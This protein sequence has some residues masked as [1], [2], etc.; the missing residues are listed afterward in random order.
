MTTY[1]FSVHYV[2]K[3]GTVSVLI[4]IKNILL[5]EEKAIVYWRYDDSCRSG[6]FLKV[7]KGHEIEIL[8]EQVWCLPNTAVHSI[9]CN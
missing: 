2:Y 8:Y 7:V 3:C 4:L 6:I 5:V 1:R 9:L